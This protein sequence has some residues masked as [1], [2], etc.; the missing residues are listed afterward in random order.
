MTTNTPEPGYLRRGEIRTIRRLTTLAAVATPLFWFAH[1]AVDPGV[2]DP[3]PLRLLLTA[4]CLGV[5]VLTYVR[6]RRSVLLLLNMVYYSYAMWAVWL[7]WANHLHPD[8]AVGAMV[9][10]AATS[11][12]F[13]DYRG[14]AMYVGVTLTAIGAAATAASPTT[15]QLNGPLFFGYVILFSALAFVML[16]DRLRLSEK[17]AASRLRYALAANGANDGLW[18]WDIAEDRLYL[19]GRWYEMLGVA[20][21]DGVYGVQRWLDRVHPEDAP[22]VRAELELHRDGRAGHFQTEFRIRHGDGTWRWFDARGVGVRDEAGTVIRMAGSQT[23]ITARKSA[24]AQ[25]VHD[26]F[27]DALTGLPNRALLADRLEQVLTNSRRHRKDTFA[28]LYLDLDR[29]KVVNDTL[30]HAAGDELLQRAAARLAAPL[31]QGDTVARLGGDEFA[32]VLPNVGARDIA[33]VVERVQAAVSRPIRIGTRELATTASIGVVLGPGAYTEAAEILRDADI[34]MYRAKAQGPGR[35][36]VFDEAIQEHTVAQLELEADLRGAVERG[37]LRL[38]YQP[39]L[40]LVSGR[41]V[42]FEALV[43]WEHPGRGLL[44]PADFVALAEES[45][46]IVPIGEW[47]LREAAVQAA[48]WGGGLTVNVNV[49]GRQLAHPKF[50]AHVAAALVASGLEPGRLQLEITE[51]VLLRDPDA[52]IEVLEA[53]REMGV[54]LYLDDFGT[55]YSSFTYLHLFPIDAVKLD[56]SFVHRMDEDTRNDAIVRALLAMAQSLGLLVVAEGVERTEEAEHLLELGCPFG[57]GY[58][59]S[60]PLTREAAARIAAP[61]GSEPPAGSRTVVHTDPVVVVGD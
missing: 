4:C 43:R 5:V 47:V 7:L 22:A 36:A 40:S 14:L 57:Q 55:G 19:S 46:V 20:G 49:S 38:E 10:V 16:R 48:A 9:V 25:L 52:A 34:A 13:F 15:T 32:I 29:F 58:L 23:D 11:I 3:F 18:D 53:L 60:R 56:R 51:S 12:G 44:A 24:E 6:P 21:D 28:L 26:A 17:L 31:R 27:H 41:L 42:G 50:A 2:V 35:Y 61:G 1:R 8:F 33:K 54:Q 37:E 45:G 39:I 30:G 59:F